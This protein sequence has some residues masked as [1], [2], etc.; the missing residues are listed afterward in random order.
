MKNSIKIGVFTL[1]MFSLLGQNLKAQSNT[2]TE[3]YGSGI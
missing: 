1:S 2:K 3:T